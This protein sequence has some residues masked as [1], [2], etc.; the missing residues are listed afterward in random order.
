MSDRTLDR[1][2]VPAPGVLRPARFPEIH[3]FDL[4]N[5]VPVWFCETDGMPVTTVRVLHPSG[6]IREDASRAGLAT[7]TGNLLESGTTRL[8][9]LEIARTLE[10]YGVRVGTSTSWEV[11]SVDV[12][13]LTRNLEAVVGIM[14]ELM[15]DSVFPE[16]EVAR[17]RHEQLAAIRQR[18]ADPRHLADEIINRFIFAEGTPF[19]RPASGTPETVSAITRNDVVDFHQRTFT[20]TGAAVVVVGKLDPA[21]ARDLA[22]EAFGGWSG[23]PPPPASGVA[24]A[25]EPGVQV[26]VVDR[27]GSVQ[28]EIRVGH[29]GVARNTPDFFPIAVMN[30]ILGGAF[31]SRLNLNL[32]E[33]HGFTYGV[34]SSFVMRR[35]PGPFTV[36]TAVQT[37]VTGAAVREIVRELN[38][39]REELVTD[40]ELTDARNYLAGTYPLRLQ[41][42]DGVASRL[43]ELFI[44]DLPHRYVDE[45]PEQVLAVTRERVL[46]AAVEHLRP[47]DLTILAVGDASVVGSQLEELGL[48]PVEVISAEGIGRTAPERS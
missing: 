31:S 28:S 12:T 37:E 41:T 1:S 36:A 7:L 29:L 38:H 10:S 33:K 40:P 17:L 23:G 4:S 26:V 2:V 6:A 48:A 35:Q 21:R 20:P 16:T 44:Y 22:E 5:G 15:T 14:A 43:S 25:R 27:P 9:A 46:S 47:D 19:V 42:T 30:T 24:R 13:S 3:R 18:R 39:I 34:N 11:G 32:R 8:T 45:F